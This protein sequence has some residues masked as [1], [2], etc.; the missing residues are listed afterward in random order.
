LTERV[1]THQILT[2][3]SLDSA[4]AGLKPLMESMR[5]NDFKNQR[6]IDDG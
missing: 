1:L 4:N 3:Q 2:Q 6:T 5:D